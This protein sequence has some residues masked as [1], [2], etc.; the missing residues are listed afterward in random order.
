MPWGCS[1]ALGLP[2]LK[3]HSFKMCRLFHTPSALHAQDGKMATSSRQYTLCTFC[4]MG[5]VGLYFFSPK[6]WAQ[7]SMEEAGLVH[8][9]ASLLRW[10]LWLLGVHPAITP[11]HSALREGLSLINGVL[12]GCRGPCLWLGPLPLCADPSHSP[13]LPVLRLSALPPH[14]PSYPC[15]EWCLSSSKAPCPA[16][17][18]LSGT[19]AGTG[20]SRQRVGDVSGSDCRTGLHG[21]SLFPCGS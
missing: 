1:L 18:P 7:V 15:I 19:P 10:L 3:P 21:I 2:M 14:H 13:H 20:R 5:S 17:T 12:T 8:E 6:L 4:P 16:P 11:G 9:L